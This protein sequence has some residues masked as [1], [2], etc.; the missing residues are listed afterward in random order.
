VNLDSEDL[1]NLA[2]HSETPDEEPV[3]VGSAELE[4]CLE[5][6]EPNRRACIVHAFIEGYTHEQIA[7]KLGT[8]LGTVKSWVRRGLLSLKECLA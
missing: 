8:P 6:L 3:G 4:H 2:S 1:E 5:Q 7:A